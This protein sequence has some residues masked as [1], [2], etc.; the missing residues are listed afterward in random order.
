MNWQSW[1]TSEK[2]A[3]AALIASCASLSL[4]LVTAFPQLK[5][6]I[7]VFRDTVLWLALCFVLG[8]IG[9]VSYC[10]YQE[11]ATSNSVEPASDFVPQKRTVTKPPLPSTVPPPP[12][13]PTP[14]GKVR[15]SE[16]T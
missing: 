8:G 10:Q 15:E 3:L 6:A 2:L 13:A 14:S 4:S 7:I 9:Y 5:G 16:L 1:M 12:A 11:K